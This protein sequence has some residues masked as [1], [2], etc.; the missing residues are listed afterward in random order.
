MGTDVQGKARQVSR[1]DAAHGRITAV[2]RSAVRLKEAEGNPYAWR[3][4]SG[5]NVTIDIGVRSFSRWV[6]KSRRSAL[7]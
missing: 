7:A 6:T 1:V 3:A 5:E 4:F 2:L